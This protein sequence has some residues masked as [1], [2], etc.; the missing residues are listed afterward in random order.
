M[1]APPIAAL[2]ISNTEAEPG[3]RRTVPLAG[4]EFT[5]TSGAVAATPGV[6]PAPGCAA[7]AASAAMPGSSDPEGPSALVEWDLDNDGLYGAPDAEPTGAS[8]QSPPTG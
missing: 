8:T 3:Q 5:F 1:N 7:T 6:A 2:N 4:Q